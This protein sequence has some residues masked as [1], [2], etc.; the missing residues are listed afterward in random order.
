[1]EPRVITKEAFTVVGIPFKGLPSS[2][3]YEDGVNNNEIGK[4]WDELNARAAEIKN[5]SGPG[6][7][8]CFAMPNQ[9]EPW[10]IGGAEVS[11]VEDVPA[12]MVVKHVPAQRYA[13]FECTLPTI[14]QTYAFITE[15]W[16][17]TSGYQ[18]VEA[19]DFELYDETWDDND[20]LG[21]PMYIYWP[22]A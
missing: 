5:W 6:I 14:G 20:P 10:Y 13:V 9:D 7:G 17:A 15:Q 22:I 21:S 4:A 11:R 8:L 12:D 16:Q 3:P 18:H 1:M 19:P 2:G